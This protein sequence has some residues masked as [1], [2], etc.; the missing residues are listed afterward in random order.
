MRRE[1][2]FRPSPSDRRAALQY[3]ALL[4][5]EHALLRLIEKLRHIL[6]RAHTKLLLVQARLECL[7]SR[8]RPCGHDGDA[9]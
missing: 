4:D 6:G 5:Q 3:A 9:P 8:L 2:P 7:R 1:A